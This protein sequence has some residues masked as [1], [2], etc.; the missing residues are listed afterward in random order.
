[1]GWCAAAAT[2]V[3]QALI[4]HSRLSAARVVKFNAGMTA[5]DPMTLWLGAIDSRGRLPLAVR[6]GPSRNLK[7]HAVARLAQGCCGLT[8]ALSRP[9]AISLS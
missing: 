4:Q 7:C 1:M 5:G 9:W 6:P 8:L 2:S 3:R